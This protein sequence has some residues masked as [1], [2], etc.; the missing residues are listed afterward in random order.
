[1]D[2]VQ[3]FPVPE[4]GDGVVSLR[5]SE[6][7]PHRKGNWAPAYHFFAYL[8]GLYHPIGHIHLRIGMNED[9]FYGGH[10]GYGVQEPYRGHGYARRFCLLVPPVAR[11]H[12]MEELIITTTSDNLPSLRTIEALGAT[13]LG[14]SK[15]PRKS[16][17]YARGM[18]YVCRYVWDISA[19]PP[20]LITG[21]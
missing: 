14:E 13:Y 2:D 21:P 16:E 15:I 10:I 1:M 17:L 12:G 18:R 6:C 3:F 19:Y 8:P 11:S 5:L 9:L 20:Y 4:L 7:V